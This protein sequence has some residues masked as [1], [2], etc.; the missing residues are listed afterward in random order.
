[1]MPAFDLT[2]STNWGWM[3]YTFG[4][5]SAYRQ[6]RWEYAEVNPFSYQYDADHGGFGTEPWEMLGLRTNPMFYPA[7][8]E[9]RL[10]LYNPC[11]I[12]EADFIDGE[13]YK[14][15]A[16]ALWTSEIQSSADGAMWTTEY[17]I[18]A[19]AVAA[20]WEVWNRDEALTDG[21]KW[22]ALY[23]KGGLFELP[24]CYVRDDYVQVDLVYL[25]LNDS[26]TPT[27]IF[28]GDEQNTYSLECRLTN[29]ETGEA[30]DLTFTIDMNE[31]LE[32]DTD[33]KMVTYLLDGSSQRTRR[34]GG[35]RRTFRRWAR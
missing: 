14:Q 2:D 13:K 25:T 3:Y 1:M 34:R 27:V 18:A 15:V 16:S 22:V 8:G 24:F 20:S 12:L 10:Y 30:I 33:G 26:Y 35:T 21:A 6:Q 17:S 31:T 11:G 23:L 28:L 19:P 32:V 5:I 4:G 7:I 29:N 9:A